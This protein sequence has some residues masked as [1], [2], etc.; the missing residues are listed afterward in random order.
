MGGEGRPG[1]GKGGGVAKCVAAQDGANG[2]K[3]HH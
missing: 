1:K 3:G 2:G